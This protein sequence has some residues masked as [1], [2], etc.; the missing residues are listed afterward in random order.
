M[1]ANGNRGRDVAEVGDSGMRLHERAGPPSAF[2]CPECGGALWELIR[3]RIK[4]FRCHVGHVYSEEGLL[5]EKARDLEMALWTA[6]R[7]LEEHA[8]LRR[9]MATEAHE[10]KLHT[11]ASSYEQRAVEAEKNATLIRKILVMDERA[12][13]GSNEARE[14]VERN[15]SIPARNGKRKNNGF[16]NVQS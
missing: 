4:Q 3:G 11:I 5:S 6:V 1:S 8:G 7:T 13:V 10:R 14:G 12:A 15:A 9:K 16:K 2:T